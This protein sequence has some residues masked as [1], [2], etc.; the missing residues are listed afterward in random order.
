MVQ[1]ATGIAS[2]KP[3]DTVRIHD[4]HGVVLETN[5]DEDGEL[6]II[7]VQTARNVFRGYGPEYID[8]RLHPDAIS[9]ATTEDLEK[10]IQTH[11]R[12]LDGAVER[13]LEEARQP[14]AVVAD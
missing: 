11:R 5:Y 9:P 4:W 13:L 7:R 14:E 8:V 2:L 3:G 10:E 12:V 1:K 6:S